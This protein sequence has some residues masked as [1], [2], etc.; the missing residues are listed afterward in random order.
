MNRR[1]AVLSL[2]FFGIVISYVDRGDLS[3]AAPSMMRDFA[4][5]PAAMGV[6]LSAFFWTYGAFQIPS[7]ILVDRL[8]I[9]RAYAAGFLIWSVASASIALSRG[10]GDVIGLR[11]M[12]GFAES[13]GPLA[14]LSF[15]R[16]NFEGKD[17]GLPTAI[18]I[19]GQSI[20]PALGALVG[21]ALLDRFGWRAMFAATGLGALVWLPFW[22]FTAPRDREAQTQTVEAAGPLN[23]RALV[24]GK[25]FWALSL[26]I[27]LASY[28]WYF[29]LTWV[30][31]YLVLSKGFTTLQ[32]GSIVSICLFA[33]AGTNVIAGFAA[34]RLAARIGV[35][36]SR[37][38][39]AAA[40]YLGTAA[41][42]LLLVLRDRGWVLPVLAFSICATGAGNASFWALVQ[43]VSP[44]RMA[45]RSVGYLNTLS[46][47][48][49]A[50]AP[51]ITGWILG[52]EKQFGPAILVAG[53]CPVLAAVCLLAAG[54][55]GL[56]EL[57]VRME[58]NG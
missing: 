38:M 51:V 19:G 54:S 35:C 36:R 4:I 29:V 5:T 28:Y 50:A 17:Q 2:V 26:C 7:G 32:M 41:V 31:S 14:S 49:G 25:G 1:W 52:P 46:Q 39:F 30:P 12:L 58:K 45:G 6:V 48:A 24:R 20:G 22:W 42:L 3:I 15:I 13:V 9:R 47:V 21:A 55:G 16:N 56:D 33:M 43:Q 18:Y 10:S 44:R 34:D 8:G 37:V 57:Q 11:M 53:I 40:G 23:W 27:L